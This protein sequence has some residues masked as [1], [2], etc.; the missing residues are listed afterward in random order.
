MQLLSSTKFVISKISTNRPKQKIDSKGDFFSKIWGVFYRNDYSS[1]SHF[2]YLW[3]TECTEYAKYA[4]STEYAK[5]AECP[6]YADY[7]E[8]ANQ[9]Y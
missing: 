8:F 4:E 6:E 5:Y 3:Y 9:D 2:T 7:A 1:K